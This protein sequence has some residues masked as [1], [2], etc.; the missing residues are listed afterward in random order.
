MLQRLCVLL[1]VGAALAPATANAHYLWVT[2]DRGDGP[3]GRVNIYF[4]EAPAVG[5]GSYLD[6]FL[7]TSETWFRTVEQIEPKPL[8]LAEKRAGEKKRWMTAPLPAAAPR[9]VECHWLFGVYQYGE[10]PVLLHYYARRLDVDSHEDLHELSRAEKMALDIVPH[11]LGDKMELKVVWNGAPVA[12][13]LVHVRG[14]NGFKKNVRTDERGVVRFRTDAAGEY[15]FRTSVEEPKA[16]RHDGENY[17]LI[18]HNAT[19]IMTLPLSK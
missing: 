5:D 11:D 8:A 10:T 12:D 14:P 2:L 4:E 18:R 17:D 15:S 16:G 3:R 6:P 13:R 9:S 19:L 1:T 7:D